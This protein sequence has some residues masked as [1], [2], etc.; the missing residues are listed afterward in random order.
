MATIA[1]WTKARMYVAR[2]AGFSRGIVCELGRTSILQRLQFLLDAPIPCQIIMAIPNFG[3]TVKSCANTLSCKT[4]KRLSR[5][6]GKITCVEKG[7]KREGEDNLLGEGRR[8]RKK[9]ER[10]DKPNSCIQYCRK[11]ILISI[12]FFVEY[13]STTEEREHSNK[14]EQ[15]Y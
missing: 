14:E 9:Q 4:S 12:H 11:C 1:C 10:E 8:A 2:V 13:N 6:K 7:V 15:Q 5:E 3:L